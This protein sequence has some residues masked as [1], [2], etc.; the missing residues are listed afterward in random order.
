M[1]GLSVLSQAPLSG[2][3]ISRSS[4][5]FIG[6]TYCHCIAWSNLGKLAGGLTYKRTFEIKAVTK[7]WNNIVGLASKRAAEIRRVVSDTIMETT[8]VKEEISERC[9][10]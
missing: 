7:P 8:K 9:L 4:S 3:I 1:V 5:E 10:G 2:F 6:L